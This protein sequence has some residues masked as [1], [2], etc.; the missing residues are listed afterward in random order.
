[1]LKP[2]PIKDHLISDSRLLWSGCILM[3]F[4]AALI[5]DLYLLA[6][7]PF[8]LLFA[9]VVIRDYR[10]LYYLFYLVIPFSVEVY[11]P[12]GLG[13]DLPSEPLMWAL[14]ALGLLLFI[15]K[16]WSHTDIRRY[17]TPITAL[18]I[19]HVLWIA[20]SII[21]SSDPLRSTKFL[22][23][24]IWYVIPF[25]FMTI[26]VLKSN[27]SLIKAFKILI[28]ML[29]LAMVYV[30][31]RH[32]AE[33]FSFTTSNNVVQPFFRNHV[34]YACMVVL[35]LPYLFLLFVRSNHKM[36]YT[37][38][39]LFYLIC[40]YFSF[41]RAAIL[42]VGIG[43][44]AYYI[45]KLKLVRPVLLAASI[46]AILG[47]FYLRYDNNFLEL[48]PNFEKTI[49]HEK[50]DNLIEATYKMEDISTMERLYRWV[51]GFEM[52]GERPVF[53]FGPNNFYINYEQYALSAFQT[54]VSDNPDQSGVHNYYLMTAV[55]QGLPGLF[56]FLA[57]LFVTLILGEK[58]FHSSV[59]Q[60]DRQ[61]IMTALVSLIIIMSLNLINDMM[62]TDKVGSFFFIAI[63]IVN[64]YHYKSQIRGL[65]K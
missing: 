1:M 31:F 19:L 8:V 7:I 23:A 15:S 21:Y 29:T 51:A 65:E 48:A 42:S 14:T 30:F 6:A 18:I 11:L 38:L 60:E 43:I 57:L 44:G 20:F 55:D 59:H 33:E 5:S 25:Y 58:A 10:S 53:G 50:F 39:L 12:N 63:A 3:S 52:V 4:A 17:R 27:D 26:H 46:I 32:A 24:K 49:T 36:M 2:L 22:L 64:I 56:I 41:T 61:I 35:I 62:E 9:L 54:Y 28:A 16:S 34:N 45:I 37:G 40:I 47:L 13:T